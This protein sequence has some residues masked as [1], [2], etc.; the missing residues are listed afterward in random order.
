[1]GGGVERSIRPSI[2]EPHCS[3]GENEQRIMGGDLKGLK[4]RRICRAPRIKIF[5]SHEKLNVSLTI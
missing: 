3:G 1:M 5:Q 2:T 4:V